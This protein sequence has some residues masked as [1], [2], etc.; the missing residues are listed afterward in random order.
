M[1]KSQGLNMILNVF[2]GPLLNA[3]YG[4]GNQVNTAINSFV[5]NFTTALNPQIVKS[6][7]IGEMHYMEELIFRGA[8][9][10]PAVGLCASSF[11][12]D[13]ICL[14][15]LVK[16]CTGI[17]GY[18]YAFDDCKFIIGVVYVC[19]GDFYSGNRENQVVSDY[20]GLYDFAE[21]TFCVV[22]A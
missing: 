19:D 17:C 14:E 13:R 12:G 10:L 16:E 6:Y 5:Q 21:F 7:A 18:F 20:S 11:D 9:L 15:C 4:I 8:K 1:C 3:A 22:I 2:W